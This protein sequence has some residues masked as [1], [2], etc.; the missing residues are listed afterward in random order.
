ML[1]IEMRHNNE[2]NDYDYDDNIDKHILHIALNKMSSDALVR[3][4]TQQVFEFLA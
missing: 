1:C 4:K 2:N 3:A